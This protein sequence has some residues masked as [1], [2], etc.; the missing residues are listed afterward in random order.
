M[1]HENSEEVFNVQSVTK[2]HMKKCSGAKGSFLVE[3]I[4]QGEGFYYL[5]SKHGRYLDMRH[6]ESDD[7]FPV[8]SITEN[9]LHSHSGANDAFLIQLIDQ[10]NGYYYL[11][12]KQGRYLDMRQEDGEEVFPAESITESHLQNSLAYNDS[13]LVK[14]KKQ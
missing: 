2:K 1:R 6:E 5:K 4:D 13:F 14:L 8:Q 3:L 7:G 11:K 9:H 10:G 12:S